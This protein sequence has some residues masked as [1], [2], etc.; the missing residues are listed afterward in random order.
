[1]RRQLHR[2]GPGSGSLA[3]KALQRQVR[4]LSTMR[5]RPRSGSDAMATPRKT[6]FVAAV[7]QRS[8]TTTTPPKGASWQGHR[9]YTAAAPPS[10]PW[11]RR[12]RR[13]N[14]AAATPPKRIRGSDLATEAMRQQLRRTG[15][16]RRRLATATMRRQP[17][18]KG[19]SRRRHRIDINAVATPP[20]GARRRRPRSDSDAAELRGK[21]HPIH[22][23]SANLRSKQL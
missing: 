19:A 8:E 21:R 5:R 17:C 3:A 15:A 20:K 11:R 6:G 14:A 2:K 16:L 9:S 18:G 10:G 13:G 12:S 7:S 23:G 4:Q 22:T 1:M